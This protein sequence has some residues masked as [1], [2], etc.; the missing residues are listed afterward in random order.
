MAVSSEQALTFLAA[1]DVQPPVRS[2]R[3]LTDRQASILAWIG[4]FI[5]NRG[6]PPTL[7]EIGAA[8]GIKSTNG[9]NDHLRALERKGYVT[10]GEG[11]AR[12][13]RVIGGL[14]PAPRNRAATYEVLDEF[15]PIAVVEDALVA[16]WRF[17][18]VDPSEKSRRA[19]FRCLVDLNERSPGLQRR[20]TTETK[21]AR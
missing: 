15:V 10:R 7:R 13:L 5:V 20:V 8:F 14:P 12:S 17:L 16:C 18:F 19:A 2:R 6:M 4:D 9:V 21:S 11:T 1:G 3:P